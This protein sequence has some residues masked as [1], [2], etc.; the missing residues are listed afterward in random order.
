M[1]G[2]LALPS[3]FVSVERQQWS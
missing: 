2:R 3:L 1:A